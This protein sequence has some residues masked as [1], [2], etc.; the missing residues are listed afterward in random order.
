[1]I[2]A[3]QTLGHATNLELL[4]AVRPQFPEL[5]VTTI[6]RMTNR[7]IALG[8]VGRG[9]SLD[10]SVL[11]DANPVPH[12]HF[13]CTGCNAIRDL[14]VSDAV[15]DEVRREIGEDVVKRGLIIVG[16][17]KPCL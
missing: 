11:I 7:L 2:D 15:Y 1:M 13:I 8:I 4:R 6:H 5:T 12:D 16:L 14:V 9:P 17:C 10:G 3:L